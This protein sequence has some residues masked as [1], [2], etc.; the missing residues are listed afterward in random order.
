MAVL[1]G[2]WACGR[3]LEVG[4]GLRR[5]EGQPR[6]EAEAAAPPPRSQPSVSTGPWALTPLGTVPILQMRKVR[7]RAHSSVLTTQQSSS[8]LRPLWGGE[9]SGCRL[10]TGHL[11]GSGPFGKAK[12]TKI[13]HLHL[14]PG[15]PHSGKRAVSS[16]FWRMQR[17]EPEDV[18]LV[19]FLRALRPHPRCASSPPDTLVRGVCVCACVCECMSG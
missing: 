10:R 7:F 5:R 14:P 16:S 2:D 4:T 13:A 9:W 19:R 15:S 17:A 12:D 8:G 1:R 3:E 6:E 18:L 11:S